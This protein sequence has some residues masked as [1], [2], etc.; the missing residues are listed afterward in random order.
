M[1]DLMPSD[2]TAVNETLPACAM[3]QNQQN[4]TRHEERFNFSAMFSECQI[5]QVGVTFK[6][7][8]AQ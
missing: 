6:S 4:F 3:I 2:F 1:I 7:D 5:G 8:Q